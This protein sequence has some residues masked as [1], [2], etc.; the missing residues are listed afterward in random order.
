MTEQ[1]FAHES[2]VWTKRRLDEVDA[3]VTEAEKAANE[4]Q[5]T[6]R[7]NADKALIRLRQSQA[8]LKAQ[9]EIL[10]AQADETK[11]AALM[12]QKA[13][14]EEW[15]E[16]EQ[17]F[18]A[19]LASAGE[20]S[21][22]ARKAIS[23]RIEAQRTSFESALNDLKAQAQAAVEKAGAE[24]DAAVARL[25]EETEKTKAKIGQASSAG[26]ETWAAIKAGIAETKAVHEKTM[27]RITDAL[28]KLF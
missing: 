11:S 21:D 9:V 23:A 16:V 25:S 5:E 4:L 17:A 2:I 8:K 12:A 19:F 13:M 7:A 28:A 6:A 15:V 18:Q 22:V 27:K 26:E 14:E 1:S 20:Q 3:M 24:F 10:Q